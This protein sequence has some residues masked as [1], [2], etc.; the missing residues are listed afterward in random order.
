M[1][2]TKQLKAVDTNIIVR[3]LT[4]D[5]P[6]LA[7]QSQKLFETAEHESLYIP[8]VI[9]AETV[10]VL[11]HVYKLKRSD[12][13]TKLGALIAQPAFYLANSQVINQSLLIYINS[14]KS[15]ADCYLVALVKSGV[16]HRA[17]TFDKPLQLIDKKISSPE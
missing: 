3:F 15:F 13:V 8:D 16:C 4:G 9:L 2:T 17:Y 1:T 10:Y 5:S 12:I 14:K 11:E 7:D 6:S